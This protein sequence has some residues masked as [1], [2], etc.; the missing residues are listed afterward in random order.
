MDRSNTEYVTFR[1]PQRT[2]SLNDIS[3]NTHNSTL[4]DTTVFSLPNSSI[5]ETQISKEYQ[6]K[7]NTLE[8]QLKSANQE[9]ENL[10]LDVSKLNRELEKAQKTIDLF[11]RLGTANTHSS[12][13]LSLR[14]CKSKK[15][16]Q[17]SSTNCT[18]NK[19]EDYKIL[20]QEKLHPT[21][22]T[23]ANLNLVISKLTLELENSQKIIDSYK[24]AE[25][26]YTNTSTLLSQRDIE[27]I[28]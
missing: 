27:E 18:P 15:T 22:Q 19:L 21:S 13:P 23:I 11:K 20:Y 16:K 17:T 26:T 3:T 5:N 8:Q 12:T 1:K 7:I 4:F 2:S 10:S 24:N 25:T 28:G 14:K 9:I 6:D